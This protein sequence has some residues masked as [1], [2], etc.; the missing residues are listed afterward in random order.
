MGLCVAVGGMI[1]C[2]F[3]NSL[4]L[5]REFKKALFIMSGQEDRNWSPKKSP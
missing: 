1:A 4:V 2:I 5:E 3:C